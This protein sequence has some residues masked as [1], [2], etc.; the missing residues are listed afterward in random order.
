MDNLKIGNRIKQRRSELDMTQGDIARQI[1]VAVSTIQ[2]Y[3]KGQ[4][5]KIKLPVIEAIAR[6]LQV[7]PSWLIGKTDIMNTTVP[8][9]LRP[10][11]PMKKIPLVGEIACGTPILAEQNIIDYVDLPEHI[12][13]DYTLKCKG[14]SMIDAG[15]NDGDIVYI[16]QQEEVENGQIAAVIIDGEATLKRFY[17]SEENNA[18]TLSAAN[19]KYAP[20]IYTGEQINHLQV[21]GLA[22]AFTHIIA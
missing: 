12:N 15:I 8:Y 21:C 17:A 11:M 1:G 9:N 2:R 19:P 5:E 6:V 16:R 14:D 22:V 18:V 4:I 13:A 7:E 20:R 3:E 10:L